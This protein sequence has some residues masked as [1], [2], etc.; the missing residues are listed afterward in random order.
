MMSYLKY[1]FIL[2]MLLFSYNSYAQEKPNAIVQGPFKTDLFPDGEIYFE[3]SKEAI[4]NCYPIQFIL[5]YKN[6]N[7]FKIMKIDDYDMAPF[8]PELLSVFFNKLHGKQYIFTIIKT[9][10]SVVTA[11][12][13]MDVYNIFAYTKNSKGLLVK[14][15]KISD[16]S[17]LTGYEGVRL[18]KNVTFKYKTATD[19]K[20]YLK[21]KYH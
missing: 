7:E 21:Q 3:S 6:N 4:N 17:S 12:D 13:Y 1:F 15:K 8:C 9:H 20:Q 14:D 5:K 2:I 10:I 11:G 18:N 16:D 19:V